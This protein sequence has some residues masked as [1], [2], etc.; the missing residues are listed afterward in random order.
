MTLEHENHID[1][2]KRIDDSASYIKNKGFDDKYYKDL[3]VE[4]LKQY[5][6]AKKK[7][8]R[9]LLWGKLPEVLSDTQKENKMRNL[10]TSMKKAGI[11]DTDSDNQQKSNWILK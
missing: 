8:I 6:S 4:Y 3:I 11:I 10:L 1:K 5:K 9:D 2:I 7:D